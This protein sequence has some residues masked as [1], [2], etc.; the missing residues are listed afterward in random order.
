MGQAWS[1]AHFL[2][3]SVR[4]RRLLDR[5]NAVEAA[6]AVN[7]LVPPGQEG[8]HGLSPTVGADDRMHLPRGTPLRASSAT[9]AILALGLPLSPAL[10]AARWIVQQPLQLVEL[11]LPRGEHEVL[12]AVSAPKRPVYKAHQLG[13][14]F[15]TLSLGRLDGSVGRSLYGR[16]SSDFHSRSTTREQ[17]SRGTTYRRAGI[18]ISA[19]AI[20][21]RWCG[22]SGNVR[23]SRPPRY[24]S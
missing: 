19:F 23:P 2:G 1:L 8:N 5:A 10:G 22:A 17:L 18:Y 21:I 7:R 9:N 15:D 4:P 12:T 6:A 24:S 11:L 20:A 16:S 13:P 3:S 14:S